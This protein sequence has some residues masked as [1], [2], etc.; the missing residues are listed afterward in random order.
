MLE[1]QGGRRSGAA[2]ATA[3]KEDDVARITQ[4]SPPRGF[5]RALLAAPNHVYRVGLGWLLGHRFL[6]LVHEG[7]RT[8]R[9]RQTVLEVVRY[10]PATHE[11][12]V[13]AGWGRRTAWLHNVEAGLAREVRTGRDRY[14]PVWRVLP[15]SER[16]A[17]LHGYIRGHHLIRPVIR[18]VLT[19]LLGWPFD[20]SGQ[21]IER[22]A[23]EL[24]M[25]G[26]R[27]PGGRRPAGSEATV[28]LPTSVWRDH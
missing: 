19:W 25:I 5:L 7:R 11:S 2:G 26:F 27:P 20:G 13:V 9:C 24:P 12:I 16:A 4:P 1:S 28:T 8:G 3:I 14:R 22:A 21:A 10:D 6:M 17:V 15:D 23:R 18:R